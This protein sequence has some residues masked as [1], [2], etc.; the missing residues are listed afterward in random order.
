MPTFWKPALSHAFASAGADQF[1]GTPRK[2]TK[3]PREELMAKV[4]QLV[5]QFGIRPTAKILGISP[6]YVHKLFNE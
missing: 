5:P 1:P 2:G 3:T 6:A 4:K